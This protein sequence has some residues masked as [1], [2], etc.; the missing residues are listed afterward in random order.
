MEFNNNFE[1]NLSNPFLENQWN[2][3]NKPI[4][5]NAVNYAAIGGHKDL[6]WARERVDKE[7]KNLTDELNNFLS[8]F[9]RHMTIA[10]NNSDTVFRLSKTQ[11]KFQIVSNN[12]ISELVEGISGKFAPVIKSISKIPRTILME[13]S[14]YLEVGLDIF[15][16]F[17]EIKQVNEFLEIKDKMEVNLARIN[18]DF[19]YFINFIET[20]LK[21]EKEKNTNNFDALT[22]LADDIILFTKFIKNISNLIPSS[23]EIEFDILISWLNNSGHTIVQFYEYYYEVDY[24]GA[25]TTLAPKRYYHHL[26]SRLRATRILQPLDKVGVFLKKISTTVSGLYLDFN[27]S[28]FNLDE[29]FDLSVEKKLIELAI[30]ENSLKQKWGLNIDGEPGMSNFKIKNIMPNM[31]I[32][33]TLGLLEKYKIDKPKK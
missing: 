9:F 24:A 28:V 2:N 15:D 20:D 32:R 23:F 22:Q 7:I 25:G 5:N 31:V 13:F 11:T 30:D 17:T 21:K 12:V 27:A 29:Y 3:Y 6:R 19:E 1:Q 14:E 10:L 4:E 33:K 26:S 8:K 16:D 18:R